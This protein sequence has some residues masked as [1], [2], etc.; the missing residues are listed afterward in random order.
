MFNQHYATKSPK[1]KQALAI[2]CEISLQ[3]AELVTSHNYFR[4]D[5]LR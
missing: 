5:S 1:F 3:K 2:F 4:F